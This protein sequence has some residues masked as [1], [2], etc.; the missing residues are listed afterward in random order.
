[1]TTAFY[2]TIDTACKF[3]ELCIAQN[4]QTEEERLK[5]LLSLK[6]EIKTIVQ[7]NRTKEEFLA[8]LA[9]NWSVGTVTR[10]AHE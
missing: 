5:I 4:A 8:D 1:M 2:M 7:T 6:D 10:K 3:Y 9:K